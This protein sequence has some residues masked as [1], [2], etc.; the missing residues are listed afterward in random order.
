MS[1]TL[2]LK[3]LAGELRAAFAERRLV[4]PP[5]ARDA[6]FAIQDAYAVEAELVRM[7]VA[8]GRTTVGLKIGAANRATWPA[9]KLETLTW[10]HLY[11]DTVH[12]ASGN[13]TSL[14]IGKMIAPKIEPEIVVKLREPVAG[15]DAAAIMSGVEW[16]ALGFEICDC[17]Y[18]D[19]QC[20]AVDSVAAYGMH[21]ALV[22]GEPRAVTADLIPTLVDQLPQFKVR[23][24]K[25]GQVVEGGVGRNCM[26]SPALCLG[27][28]ARAGTPAPGMLISTGSL[29]AAAFIAPGEEWSI[30]AE[31]IE[32]PKLTVRIR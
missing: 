9:L 23:L 17:V 29:T 24:M 1:S 22:V 12:F 5:S 20:Q 25:N 4:Q 13:T 2:D 11:D 30:E 6:A 7:R 19:W 32:L 26:D 16:I 3:K 15:T 8:S 10:A 18:P 21:A 14:S 27:E 31:G 28:L